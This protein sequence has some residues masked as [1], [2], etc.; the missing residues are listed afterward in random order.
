MKLTLNGL[1]RYILAAE[2]HAEQRPFSDSNL[3]RL[4]SLTM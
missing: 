4:L 1:T 2:T 3:S